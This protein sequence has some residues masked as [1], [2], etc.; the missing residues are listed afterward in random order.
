MQTRNAKWNADGSIDCEIHHPQ[1]GWVW[2]T[3]SPDDPEP[4]G[5]AIFDAIKGSAAPEGGAE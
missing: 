4:H 5:R 2:F 1:L 3:A